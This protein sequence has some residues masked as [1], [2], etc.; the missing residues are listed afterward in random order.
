MGA[1]IICSY[2]HQIAGVCSCCRLEAWATCAVCLQIPVLLVGIIPARTCAFHNTH[3]YQA[4]KLNQVHL[5]P[6]TITEKQNH[7][8]HYELEHSLFLN[9]LLL[10]RLKPAKDIRLSRLKLPQ[11]RRLPLFAPK[12][13]RTR[14]ILCANQKARAI[15]ILADIRLDNIPILILPRTNVERPHKL[16]HR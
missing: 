4:I 3:T 11:N 12:R 5:N 10:R 7:G 14:E 8:I 15:R 9:I 2:Q 6:Q 13:N 16:R 1:S